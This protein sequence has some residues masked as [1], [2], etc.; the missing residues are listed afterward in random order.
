MN[1]TSAPRLV[2]AHWTPSQADSWEQPVERAGRP[3]ATGHLSTAPRQRYATVTSA[4]SSLPRG[5]RSSPQHTPLPFPLS[6]FL[7]FLRECHPE[8]APLRRRS[9]SSWTNG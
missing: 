8:L 6:A 2:W 7:V 4:I 5:W 3:P 1:L 9:R